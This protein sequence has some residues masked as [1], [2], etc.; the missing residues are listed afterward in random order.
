MDDDHIP[1]KQA[2]IWNYVEHLL[3]M[4]ERQRECFCES[5][6]EMLEAAD[7]ANEILT[8]EYAETGN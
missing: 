1:T 3:M 6:D 7:I 4:T 5:V 8:G 2:R